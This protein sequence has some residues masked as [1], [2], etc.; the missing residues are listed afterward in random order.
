MQ[1]FKFAGFQFPRFVA[2]F[3]QGKRAMVAK[4]ELRKV[5]GG[6]Y[7]A[8]TP[9]QVSGWGFYDVGWD[10]GSNFNLRLIRGGAFTNWQT[11]TEVFP[12]VAR[13][14]HGRGYLAGWTM[15]EHMCAELDSRIFDDEDDA[16][17]AARDMA[18]QVCEDDSNQV[19]DYED[20]ECE[21]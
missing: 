17:R 12:I 14:N 1:S 19:D 6:Y 8:P 15:G 10:D 11:D 9:N 20:I 5:C 3:A 7:H 21:A 4:R 18:E 16:M 2:S 13:L